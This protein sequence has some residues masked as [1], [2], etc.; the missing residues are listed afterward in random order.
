MGIFDFFKGSSKPAKQPA[1]PPLA[2]NYI[3]PNITLV[4][5]GDDHV[6]L[7][8]LIAESVSDFRTQKDVLVAVQMAMATDGKAHIYANGKHCGQLP[9]YWEEAG[10]VLM[11]RVAELGRTNV[12][13]WADVEWERKAGPYTTNVALGHSANVQN[14]PLVLFSDV[15]AHWRV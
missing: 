9:S 3:R 11:A 4:M 5:S 1:L 2:V 10:R 15:K 8:P 6:N 12:T 7:F 14:L 13:L